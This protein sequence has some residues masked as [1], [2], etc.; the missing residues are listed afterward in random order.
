MRTQYAEVMKS[1][2]VWVVRW[3]SEPMRSEVHRLFGTDTL[4]TPY[5]DAAPLADVLAH[6]R[7]IPANANTA[8]VEA[9]QAA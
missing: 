6:L 4:P 7:R 9:I 1:G 3:A 2:G 8:F 5:S